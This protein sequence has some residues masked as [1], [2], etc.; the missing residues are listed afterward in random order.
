MRARLRTQN[1]TW[2]KPS[3][4]GCRN[5]SKSSFALRPCHEADPSRLARRTKPSAVVASQMRLA[6]WWRAT[7][8]FAAK[9]WSNAVLP[10]PALP[11]SRTKRVVRL[12]DGLIVGEETIDEPCKYQLEGDELG[13]GEAGGQT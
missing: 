9:C 6:D 5:S 4:K 11:Q 12:R 7:P 10:S 13:K 1:F 3:R 8:N 2:G